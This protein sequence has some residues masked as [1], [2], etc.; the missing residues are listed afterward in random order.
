[1][2]A[3]PETE[4]RFIRYEDY[5]MDLYSNTIIVSKAL[6]TQNPDAVKGFVR[7]LNRGIKDAQADRAA[8]V[9]PVLKREAL[10][11]AAI[12]RERLDLMFSFDMSAP[13]DEGRRPWRCRWTQASSAT[14]AIIVDANKLP[15]SPSLSEVFDRRLPAAG[16][17]SHQA[18]L[19]RRRRDRGPMMASATTAAARS[20]A[21]VA[22]AAPASAGRAAPELKDVTVRFGAAEQAV[23]ALQ[24]AN[25][26]VGRGEF[27]ALV[28]P[29]GC[30]KSTILKLVGGLLRPTDGL[31]PGRPG[32]ARTSGSAWRFRTP[33]L[34]PWLT[35]VAERHAAAED[36]PAVPPA[37]SRQAQRRISRSRRA[38]AK[39]VG[40][41]GVRRQISVAVVGRHAAAGIAVPRAD[42]RPEPAAARRAVRRAWISSPARSSGGSSSSCGCRIARRS[43]SSPTISARRFISRPGFA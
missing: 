10:L 1:M 22:V 38:A 6:I 29:S 20:A 7:A 8:A 13:R 35:I 43:C 25:L 18:V 17:R 30:G 16:R 26:A 11:N 32:R 39:Q 42:P 36:R 23:V 3:K 4:L 40:L 28:G 41:V 24:S 12:E 5:G 33:T 19:A 14:S 15:R 21:D 9:E 34:L 31:R 27:V 37:V 2:G